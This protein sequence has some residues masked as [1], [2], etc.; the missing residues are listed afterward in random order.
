MMPTANLTTARNKFA[1]MTV[2]VHGFITLPCG[3]QEHMSYDD[4]SCDGWNVWVRGD[5]HSPDSNGE[6]F[7]NVEEFDRDWPT[8]SL[9]EDYARQLAEQLACQV[10]HY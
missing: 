9:A 5:Y 7:I 3:G 4:P 10:D 8:P 1:F 6:L 2:M